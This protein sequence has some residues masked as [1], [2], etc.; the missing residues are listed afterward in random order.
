MQ[1]HLTAVSDQHDLTFEHV[2]ELVLMGVPMSLARPSAGWQAAKVDAELVETGDIAQSRSAPFSARLV[3]GRRI[4]RA[5]DDF[6][7]GD[8]DF[9][10][11]MPFQYW[12]NQCPAEGACSSGECFNRP[13]I[14]S[15]ALK[16]LFYAKSHS[17]ASRHSTDGS[18][19]RISVI[20]TLIADDH[21][22]RKPDGDPHRRTDCYRPKRNSTAGAVCQSALRVS[23]RPM[24]LPSTGSAP[25]PLGC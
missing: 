24:P 18:F 21:S 17:Y 8:V 1:D 11:E 23:R 6:C 10:H 3:V 22:W 16:P 4:E 25:A 12:Q 15:Y 7:L 5:F 13:F 20:A 2:D 19:V 9:R 14:C